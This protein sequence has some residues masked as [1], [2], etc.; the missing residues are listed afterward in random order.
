MFCRTTQVSTSWLTRSTNSIFQKRKP[1]AKS[2]T[3]KTTMSP[4]NRRLRRTDCIRV[5]SA[6]SSSRRRRT[7]SLTSVYVRS[8]L[9][10]IYLF[11]RFFDFVFDIFT[12]VELNHILV[13]KHLNAT[14]FELT[15]II[16]SVAYE[17]TCLFPC[18]F[19]SIVH[20][21]KIFVLVRDGSILIL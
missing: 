14:W 4:S 15:S 11:A 13:L 2:L 7:W 20:M 12:L 5:R 1:R 9:F 10:L 21:S 19:C 18:V 6:V 3:A 8:V 16:P 17:R